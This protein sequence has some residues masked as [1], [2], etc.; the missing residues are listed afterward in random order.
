MIYRPE[1]INSTPNHSHL[2]T[3]ALYIQ[4][5]GLGKTIPGVTVSPSSVNPPGVTT[6]SRYNPFNSA[7]VT[8]VLSYPS[9][10]DAPIITTWKLTDIEAF[11]RYCKDSR[12]FQYPNDEAWR[13]LRNVFPIRTM[14][15]LYAIIS[16]NR[17]ERQLPRVTLED[18][19]VSDVIQTLR[20][21]AAGTDI[22]AMYNPQDTVE[23]N[24]IKGTGH[25]VPDDMDE[26]QTMRFHVMSVL[27]ACPSHES[28]DF[29]NISNGVK[30]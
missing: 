30:R 12:I 19:E 21:V 6:S 13:A 9:K 29:L 28:S 26:A 18:L 4:W 16:M 24:L 1:K 22:N 20:G 17:S 10:S 3:Y 14:D 15:A 5:T 23:N 7:N 8:T 27:T 2:P 11:E 25:Y